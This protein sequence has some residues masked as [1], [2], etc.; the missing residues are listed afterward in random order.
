MMDK[1]WNFKQK[2]KDSSCEIPLRIED[3]QSITDECSTEEHGRLV[4][5][6]GNASVPHGLNRK[7]PSTFTL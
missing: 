7:P 2:S 4:G 6:S 3:N 5:A 1:M